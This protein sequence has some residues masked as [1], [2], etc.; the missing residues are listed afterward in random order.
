VATGRAEVERYG[1]RILAGDMVD[2]RPVEHGFTVTLADGT[3]H[4]ARRL[5][6]A[7]GLADDLPALPGLR[8]QWG[9]HVVHCPF[10]HGWEVRD[11]TIGVLALTPRAI[12]QARLFRQWSDDVTLFTHT[13][14]ELAEEAASHGLRVVAGE[15]AAVESADGR[16]TGLRLADGTVHAVETVAI[17]PRAR[18]RAPYLDGLGLAVA[19]HPSGMGEHLPVDAVGRTAV[20][21]VWAAGNITDP[22][23][24]VGMAAAQAALAAAGMVGEFAFE[25]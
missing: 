25:R 8:E 1:G 21:G 9:R 14:P 5:L 22:S 10:C 18:L 19:Q 4:Y 16:V 2:A 15:V 13:L 3:L 7:T 12:H 6:L 11:T 17:G 20:E 24:Q 23:A